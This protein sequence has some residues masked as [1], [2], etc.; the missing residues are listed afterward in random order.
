VRPNPNSPISR[1]VAC[2]STGVKAHQWRVFAFA[3]GEVMARL[4][5]KDRRAES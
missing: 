1:Y 3:E 2:A 4:S 5:G